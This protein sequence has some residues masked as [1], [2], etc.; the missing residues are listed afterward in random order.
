MRLY[1]EK[2]QYQHDRAA[3]DGDLK[4]ICA[5]PCGGDAQH[6]RGEARDGGACGVYMDGKVMTA[7]VTYGT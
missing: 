4:Q 5:E 6:Q 7:S 2:L 1:Q 3:A